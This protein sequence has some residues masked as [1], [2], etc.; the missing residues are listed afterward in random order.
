MVVFC[1]VNECMMFGLRVVFVRDDILIVIVS[2]IASDI[3]VNF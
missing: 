2:A 1:F 3:V